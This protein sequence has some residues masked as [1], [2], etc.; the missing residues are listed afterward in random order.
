MSRMRCPMRGLFGFALSMLRDVRTYRFVAVGVATLLLAEALLYVSVDLLRFDSFLSAVAVTE[1]TLLANFAL[2]DVFVFGDEGK[3]GNPLPRRLFK[4][5]ASRVV[6]IV[7]NLA[8]FYA[9]NRVL[10]VNHLLAYFVAVMVAFGVNLLTSFVW[11][12]RVR[13]V[14]SKEVVIVRALTS[15]TSRATPRSAANTSRRSPR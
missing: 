4:Y 15:S 5:H 3:R 1:V 2:N 13:P 9:L 14:N 7:V 11:V 10:L 12:W 8:V 6:S